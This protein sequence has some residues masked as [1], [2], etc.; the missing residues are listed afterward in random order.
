MTDYVLE[1]PK[2]GVSGLGT[3]GG[4]VTW[5]IDSTTPA[6]FLSDLAAAFADWSSHANIQFQEVAS[7]ASAQIDFS[8]GAI[9]GLDNTLGE[10]SYSYSGSTFNLA[11][12]EF[13]SGEGWHVAGSQVVSNDNVDLFDVALHEIGHSLGLGHYNAAPAIMN[14]FLNPAVTD[15]A[16]SDIDGI[17]AIY[18]VNE[19]VTAA[20]LSFGGPAPDVNADGKSDIAFRSDTGDV[21]IWENIGGGVHGGETLGNVGTNWAIQGTGDFDGDGKADLLWRAASGDV[22]TWDNIVNGSHGGASLGFVGT[23]WNIIATADLDGDGKT[24]ILWRNTNG[25]VVVWN[26]ITNG[27]HGGSSLGNVGWN[28][29]A[30]GDFNG[31][32]KADVLWENSAGSLVTWE[33]IDNG[34]H[35]GGS[36]GTAP[37]NAHIAGVGDFDGDGKSDILWRA[38]NGDVFVWNNISGNKH[39]VESLG[40]VG[41]NWEIESI[42]DFSGDGKADILWQNTHGDTVTWENISGSSHGGE[43][44][45]I[46]GLSWNVQ[47][48][49][50]DLM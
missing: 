9:D 29:A 18:G 8:M 31:D 42:G 32:H 35:G 3:A 12:I 46:V 48:H 16:Q 7:T 50:F 14:A 43:A 26:N 33:N 38:N 5:A 1:G 25:D 44:L 28:V 6:F 19:P 24:D 40:N 47:Q 22:V 36:L 34:T 10:T 37:T 39:S 20:A 4:T 45:G 23:N 2:W 13:D 30:T 15:L 21:A 41:L 49:H 27:S 11:N 17:Q